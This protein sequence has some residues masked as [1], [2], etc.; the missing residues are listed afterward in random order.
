MMKR[1]LSALLCA[2]VLISMTGCAQDQEAPEDLLYSSAPIQ[3]NSDSSSEEESSSEP[4]ESQAENS[5]S[6]AQNSSSQA[7]SSSSSAASSQQSSS[8]APSSSSQASSSQASSQSSSS[9]QQTSSKPSANN[10]VTAPSGEMRAVWFS[11]LDLSSMIKQKSRSE[12]ESAISKAFSNVAN[13]GYNTV[14]VQA[15]PFGDALYDS[16][17]FPW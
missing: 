8:A 13:D 4:E 9:S 1:F 15:R 12:F 11:Y 14:F 2:C 3:F 5:S 17:L 6:A 16:D 10:S 7:P